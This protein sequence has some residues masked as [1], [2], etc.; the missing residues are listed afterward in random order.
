MTATK[1]KKNTRQR[2]GTTHGWGSMK[3]HR[4][5]GNKGGAGMAGTGKRGDAKKPMIWKEKYFGKQGFKK[6]GIP[7]IIVAINL[8][9]INKKIEKLL[10]EKKITKEANIYNIDLGSLGYNKL[11]GTGNIKNKMKI[12]VDSATEKAIKKVQD[13]GGEVITAQKTE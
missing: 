4:G 9:D 11:L 5:K 8:I 2:A 3:K 7:N 12:K 1:R 10:S 6:K 13:N